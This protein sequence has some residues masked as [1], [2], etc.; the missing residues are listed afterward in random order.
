MAVPF[1]P[2]AVTALRLKT[3]DDDD[4][5]PNSGIINGRGGWLHNAPLC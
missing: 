2:F 1:C 3:D 5:E 4:S